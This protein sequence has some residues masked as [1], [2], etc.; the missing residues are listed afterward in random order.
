M[1]KIH[2]IHGP[3]LHLLGRRE[4]AVY[5]RTSLAEINALLQQD[6]FELGAEL[7]ILQSNHEGEI[8]DAICGMPGA[9]DGLVINPAAYSH[10]SIAIRDAIAAVALPAIE[11]HLS[12]IHAREEF[13]R[14]SVVAPAVTG[15]IAGLGPLGYRLALRGLVTLLTAHANPKEGN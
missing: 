3:N 8:V 14:N 13:R 9:Y 7:E 5:G 15:V 2:V 4:P 6:A 10:Y 11:V 1:P 12:N